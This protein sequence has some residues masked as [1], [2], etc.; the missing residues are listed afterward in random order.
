[1]CQI[2]GRDPINTLLVICLS[3]GTRGRCGAKAVLQACR[4]VVERPNRGRPTD[5]VEGEVVT[6]DEFRTRPDS[7][8]PCERKLDRNEPTGPE[9]W[10][11]CV[12]LSAWS[13]R[14][15][16]LVRGSCGALGWPMP[17]LVTLVNGW[18]RTATQP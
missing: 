13:K 11:H 14:F 16:A 9:G 6:V 4:K 8:Q 17:P 12:W 10:K 7:P 18:T 5:T 2:L 1:M 15:E 3:V